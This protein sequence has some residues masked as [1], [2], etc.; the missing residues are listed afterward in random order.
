MS[1]KIKQLIMA[2]DSLLQDTKKSRSPSGS[3]DLTNSLVTRESDRNLNPWYATFFGENKNI[4]LH[5][6]S[7][8]YIDVT[9]VIGI[10][11]REWPRLAYVT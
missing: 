9:Q 3:Y 10:L 1:K 2:K 11:P 5:F 6:M 8:L 4:Y 7:I